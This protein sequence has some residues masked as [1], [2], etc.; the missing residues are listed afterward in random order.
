MGAYSRNKGKRV[1]RALVEELKRNGWG[2]VSREGWKQV[3]FGSSEAPDVRA[4]PPGWG[5]AISFECKARAAGFD[6]FYGLLTKTKVLRFTDGHTECAVSHDPNE[7]WE[8][9]GYY[10][11]ASEFMCDNEKAL[12]KLLDL[13]KKWLGNADV[14][15]LKQD[16]K[17]FIFIRYSK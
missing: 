4:R 13:K 12:Y 16:R 7:V 14:L 6:A 3:R 1:E 15:V 2:E 9:C 17:P 5:T 11:Q 10:V 8:F